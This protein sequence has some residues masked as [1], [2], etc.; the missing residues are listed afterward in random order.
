MHPLHDYW[1]LS[2]WFTRFSY[3]KQ[4]YLDY[5]SKISVMYEKYFD[6]IS[7]KSKQIMSRAHNSHAGMHLTPIQCMEVLVGFITLTNFPSNPILLVGFYAITINVIVSIH[8]KLTS[9]R[10]QYWSYRRSFKQL[11]SF[12]NMGNLVD[13]SFLLTSKRNLPKMVFKGIRV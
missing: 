7:K 9:W 2:L 10:K 12:Y 8:F 11:E 13:D 6:D 3:R 4:I 5:F 1:A